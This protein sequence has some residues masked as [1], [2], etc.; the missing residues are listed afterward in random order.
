MNTSS[1]IT[2]I[3]SGQEPFPLKRNWTPFTEV[4]VLFNKLVSYQPELALTPVNMRVKCVMSK[5]LPRQYQPGNVSGRLEG[6]KGKP[7]PL[8]FI[9]KGANPY[10]L[11]VDW[12]VE[13][14][15]I[16]SRREDDACSIAE[17]Y[18]LHA[19]HIVEE[20]IRK[21]G[22]AEPPAMRMV[23]YRMIIGANLFKAD[24]AKAVYVMTGATTILDF[25][26]G[27]GDR[28]VAAL[29]TPNV[30]RYVGIDPNMDLIPAHWEMVQKLRPGVTPAIE[31]YYV[32][33]EDWPAK[34]TYDLVFT[35]P[36]FFTLEEYAT[37]DPSTQSSTRYRG[38]A[39]WKERFLFTSMRKAWELLKPGGWFMLYISDIIGKTRK[40]H[41]A[42]A[43][44]AT[45]YQLCEEMSTVLPGFR[46]MIR[47]MGERGIVRPLWVWRKSH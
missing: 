36:P 30:K 23:L 47:V 18:R 40:D 20:A 41:V 22:S 5:T 13:H 2:R 4:Q 39:E 16:H 27:W 32:P 8:T 21:Y 9:G 6:G 34:G 45:T 46:G 28:L 24:L 42:G 14:L 15:R 1:L 11:L 7:Q 38:F 44:K 37:C 29:A 25:S 17:A 43:T 3:A 10:H 12:F 35:S 31:M 26:A 19:Q 33:F